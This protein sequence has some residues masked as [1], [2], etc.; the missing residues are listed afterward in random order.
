VSVPTKPQAPARAAAPARLCLEILESRLAPATIT[1]TTTADDITPNDGTVSL[2]E[3]IT[4]I[5][6]GNDLGDPDITAQSPGTFGVNDTI[7]FNVPGAGVKTINVGTDASAAGIPLPAIVN[8]VTINGYSQPGASVNTMANSDNAVILIELNGAGAGT[9]VNGLTLGAG[10]DGST[11]KGLAIN[12][13]Q[14]D[15]SL[16]GGVGI[17]IQ[18]NGNTIVG[19]FVGVNPAGTTEMPNGGDGIRLVNASNN[20]I[21]T[22]SAADRNIASGNTLDGIHIEGTLTT[23]ATGN[24]IQ[25]NFVG[26][27]ANGVSRVGVRTAPI[28]NAGALGT[29]AGNFLF[30]IE[31][32][33][34]NNNTVGGTTAGARN[35]VGFNAD[36]V[37]IDNGGQGNIIQG[38]FAGVGADGVTPVKNLLHGIVLHSSNTFNAPLGPAQPNEPGVS[39]NLI[40][41]TA[42]GAGNL[43]EFNGTGGIAI[44]GNPVSA[45]GQPNIGNAIEGNSVF[46]NG[47]NN[48]TFLL[49]IDLT[50]QFK[51]PPDDG[52]TPNDSKG[53]GA[54]NDPNNFQNF[55]VLTSA[56]PN[57][58]KT[59]IAGTLKSSPN[60]TFRIE[61]FASNPDPAGGIPEGQQFLGF[62]NV[63]TDANGTATFSTAVNVAVA[64][65]RT[66]TA[67]ATDQ[68]G[69]TSEFSAGLTVPAVPTPSPVALTTPP[70]FVSVAFGP[71]REVLLVTFASGTLIRFDA[72]GAH[73]LFGGVRSASVAFGPAG[74]VDEIVLQDGRLVQFDASG[75]HTLGVGAT[76][77]SIAF[78]PAGKVLLV[79]LQNGTLLQFDAAGSHTLASGVGSAS[80]AFHPAGEVIVA[81]LQNGTLIQADST[82]ARIL[83]SSVRTAGVGFR[84]GSEVLEVIFL[85]GSLVQFDATGRHVLGSV[86]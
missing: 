27:A 84:S 15:A 35:V 25:G 9:A 71:A 13:F 18:S 40:G 73:T 53:H 50:N 51:F 47:R 83:G 59:D 68:I 28:P 32:S 24:L 60:S 58:G 57:A 26:V 61:F 38:N 41:G 79:T 14:A 54:P 42:A 82:G 19:N 8:P 45:S 65:G 11:I 76:S 33:G 16:N 6:A 77:A 81:T 23:P 22:P 69:N 74:E 12:R 29:D 34:G 44:F 52:L 17:V 7:N 5:N 64:N 48:P 85:D 75:A 31:I 86:L 21:G 70:P 20:L 72:T 36:G 80:V 62:V 3:A 46:L 67:T 1:V 30:G 66:I 43:V 49:G 2:R 78:G 63:T 4:A 10:S 55:P 37:E 56:V 39:F